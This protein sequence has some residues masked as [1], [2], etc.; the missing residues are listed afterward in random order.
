MSFIKRATAILLIAALTVI[1]TAVYASAQDALENPPDADAGAAETEFDAPDTYPSIY[2]T[3]YAKETDAGIAYLISDDE[4][5]I[6]VVGYRGDSGEMIIPDSIGGIPVTSI[7]ASAFVNLSITSA[8]IADSVSEIDEDAFANCAELRSVVLPS[9]LTVI[10]AGTFQNCV[11]LENIEL[12][13]KL[14]YIGDSAFEGCRLLG[15]L[16]I[17]S[18]LYEMGTDVFL[19]CEN[20]TLD[21]SENPYAADYAA[22]Y[23]IPTSFADSW[24]FTLL[25]C[26]GLTVVLGAAV[27][28]VYKVYGKRRS[29]R[30]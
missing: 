8:V 6:A 29:D 3:P 10:S 27:F 13:R 20:L 19:S 14:Q 24:T 17:P 2:A 25:L 1:F 11:R 26:A 28:V 15:V 30:T 12:P 4:K 23:G 18:A 9:G 16:K 7:T 22:S 21:C 5:S